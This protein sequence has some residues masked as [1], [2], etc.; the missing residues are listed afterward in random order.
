MNE[1]QINQKKNIVILGG[2]FGGVACAIQ[3]NKMMKKSPAPFK[4]FNYALVGKK[5]YHP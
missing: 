5:K 3:L 1:A 2:G 4:D